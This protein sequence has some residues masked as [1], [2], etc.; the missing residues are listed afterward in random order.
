[1][2]RPSHVPAAVLVLAATLAACQPD[3]LSVDLSTPAASASTA[4]TLTR[5]RRIYGA[6]VRVGNG[7]ARTYVLLDPR[8]GNPLE[9][10]VALDDRALDG[11]PAAMQK[12]LT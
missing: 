6:P 11:L 9:L 8:N 7:R 2:Y 12:H 3:V 10:G 4:R 1:M 5:V